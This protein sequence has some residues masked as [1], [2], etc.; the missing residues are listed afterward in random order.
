M[1]VNCGSSREAAWESSERAIKTTNVA[2]NSEI[3]QTATAFLS[4]M[5]IFLFR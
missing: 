2:E 5:P 1:L 4:S 3:K